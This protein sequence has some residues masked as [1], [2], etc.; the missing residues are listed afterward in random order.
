MEQAKGQGD[1]EEAT[2]GH[3]PFVGERGSTLTT[4]QSHVA[5]GGA[6][7]EKELAAIA[8]RDTLTKLN[9]PL[10]AF[11]YPTGTSP[12]CAPVRRL[13]LGC[14]LV[15]SLLTVRAEDN[16]AK[17]PKGRYAGRFADIPVRISIEDTFT[18]GFDGIAEFLEG[19][20]KGMKFGIHG[21][22]DKTG[23]LTVKRST[24]GGEQVVSPCKPWLG[25]EAVVYSGCVRG[26]GILDTEDLVFQLEVPWNVLMGSPERLLLL[27][28]RCLKVHT[29]EENLLPVA[30]LMLQLQK[31]TPKD[32]RPHYILGLCMAQIQEHRQA[33]GAFTKALELRPQHAFSL[34]ERAVSRVK[35]GKKEAALEDANK[36]LK[37]IPT[38]ARLHLKR[39]LVYDSLR[40]S[41]SALADFKR[42]NELK[43]KQPGA[44]VARAELTLNTT[45]RVIVRKV[46]EHSFHMSEF[47]PETVREVLPDLERA[48][49]LDPTHR[50]TLELLLVAYK[51]I[52]DQTKAL[53]LQKAIVQ[54]AP[55]DGRAAMRYAVDLSGIQEGKPR[56]L[57]GALRLAERVS[58]EYDYKLILQ[59]VAILHAELG[60][61]DQAIQYQEQVG[62]LG[63][64]P[65]DEHERRLKLFREKKT[66]RSQ[67]RP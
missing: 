56:D 66:L 58:K 51:T 34:A 42:A 3:R 24:K 63:L 44:Y 16:N 29:H 47:K 21:Q 64:M 40:N 41:E 13:A 43:P 26:E 28:E 27:G 45:A 1:Q 49:T 17:I 14:L 53:A 6:R 9:L 52:G 61:F 32:Y 37:M 48:R 57:R 12:M 59:V 67:P 38:S 60:Q 10:I 22:F 31:R 11:S 7:G 50:G 65:P 5:I 15:L 55:E 20:Q 46:G 8:G 39:G 19:S 36:A 18:D 33:E 62:K 30:A 54:L 2:H 25:R 23:A 4:R 35:L